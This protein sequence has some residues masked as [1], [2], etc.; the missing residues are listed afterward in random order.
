VA[1]EEE[2]EAANEVVVESLEAR[3]AA[4]FATQCETLDLKLVAELTGSKKGG[5]PQGECAKV[6]KK[7]AEPLSR[8]KKFR[9]DTLSDE[10]AV[11]RVKGDEGYALYHGNNGKNYAVQLLKEDGSWKLTSLA[12]TEI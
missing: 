3:Q 4:D 8:T 2:R 12:N 7:I 1:S 5:D 10:I 6:L 11:L 9:T